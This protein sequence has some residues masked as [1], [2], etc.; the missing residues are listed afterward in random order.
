[1]S[2][3]SNDLSSGVPVVDRPADFDALWSDTLAEARGHGLRRHVEEDTLRSDEQ[4]RMFQVNY[5]SLERV[6]IFGWLAMPRAPGPHPAVVMLPGY[7]MRPNVGVRNMAYEGLATFWVSVRGHDFDSAIRPGFPNYLTHNITDR[8]RYIYRGAYCD[9][10]LGVDLVKGMAEIDS[11]RIAVAGSSQGGALTIVATALSDGVSACAPDVP[12]LTN[13]RYSVSE[14]SSYPYAEISDLL[15]QRPEMEQDLWDTLTY[16]DV[17]NFAPL[18]KCPTLLAIGLEDN[19]CPSAATLEMGATLGGEVE[20]K[21]YP[22]TGHEHG[23]LRH[24]I[25]KLEWLRER[26]SLD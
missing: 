3:T 6:Q 10:V 7:S 15:R 24:Q 19:V 25:L 23:G 1:M 2:G 18:V 16:F 17:A 9:A 20:L 8:H 13:F 22:N 14:S 5:T 21:T 4:V 12:F 11:D 26:L